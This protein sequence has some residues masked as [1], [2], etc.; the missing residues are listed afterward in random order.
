LLKIWLKAIVL[1]FVPYLYRYA[2]VVKLNA[3]VL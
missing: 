1:V 3:F 2:T